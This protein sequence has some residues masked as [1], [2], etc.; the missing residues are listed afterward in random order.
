M[1]GRGPKLIRSVHPLDTP[2][3]WQSTGDPERPLRASVGSDEWEIRINDF[4]AEPFYSLLVKGKK[5]LDFDD[6]PPVW[7]KPAAL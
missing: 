2:V 3:R 1:T 6:W 5:V 7:T 4:P